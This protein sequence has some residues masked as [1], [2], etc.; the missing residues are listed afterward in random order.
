MGIRTA[1]CKGFKGLRRTQATFLS[2]T[3]G[4][5]DVGSPFGQLSRHL[6]QVRRQSSRKDAGKKP[7]IDATFRSRHRAAAVDSGGER[8]KAQWLESPLE[9]W[10]I[11]EDPGEIPYAWRALT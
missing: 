1:F 11:P 8:R 2:P 10:E 9:R 3:D 5:G 4:S 7:V 6:I